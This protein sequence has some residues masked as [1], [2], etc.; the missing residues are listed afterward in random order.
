VSPIAPRLLPRLVL[1]LSLAALIASAGVVS[2]F[3]RTKATH[4]VSDSSRTSTSSN[5]RDDGVWEAATHVATTTGSNFRIRFQQLRG[6]SFVYDGSLRMLYAARTRD[7][8]N[9]VQYRSPQHS[10]PLLI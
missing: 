1:L 10:L 3:S 5:T 9:A 8:S 2:G 6:A 4:A 7:S